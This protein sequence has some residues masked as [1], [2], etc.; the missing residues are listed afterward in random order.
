MMSPDSAA[1][2]AAWMVWKALKVPRAAVA[3]SPVGDTNSV[4]EMPPP[5]PLLSPSMRSDR[6]M[7]RKA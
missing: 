7:A 2:T 5:P 1:V 3:G 4:P 6:R